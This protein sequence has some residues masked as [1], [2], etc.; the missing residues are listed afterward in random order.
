MP[1]PSLQVCDGWE[2]AAA[3]A[4]PPAAGPLAANI[5]SAD[6]SRG[7]R[8]PATHVRRYP[9]LKHGDIIHSGA[10]FADVLEALLKLGTSEGVQQKGGASTSGSAA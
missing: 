9:G 10:A 6:H 4:P 5:S 1:L 3:Q 8:Q 7:S 2:A